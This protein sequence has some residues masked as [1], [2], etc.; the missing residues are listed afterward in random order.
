ME[1]RQICLGYEPEGRQRHIH[2]IQI[3]DL[4]YVPKRDLTKVEDKVFPVHTANAYMGTGVQLQ[5]FLTWAQDIS[6]W[7]TSRPGRFT[8]GKERRYPFNT[9]LWHAPEP[10]WTFRRKE[11]SL[12]STGRY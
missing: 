1:V 10:V 11:K 8:P 6:G 2:D 12:A 9:E 4:G 3:I 5:P 7:L